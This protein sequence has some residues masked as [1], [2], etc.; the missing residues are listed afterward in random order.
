MIILSQISCL[1]FMSNYLTIKKN[2]HYLSSMTNLKSLF[3]TLLLLIATL[4]QMSITAQAQIDSVG[5]LPK[6]AATIVQIRPDIFGI[7]PN[8]NT[9]QRFIAKNL[10]ARLQA[11]DTQVLVSGIIGRIPPN[12]RMMGTPFQIK[13]I[14]LNTSGDRGAGSVATGGIK[15]PKGRGTTSTGGVKPPKIMNVDGSKKAIKGKREKEL[16]RPQTHGVVTPAPTNN[17]G[18]NN[19]KMLNNFNFD[20]SNT[21]KHIQGVVQKRGDNLF[22]IKTADTQYAP[23]NLPVLYQVDGMNVTLTGQTAPPPPNVRMAGTPL[24]VVTIGTN[25]LANVKGVVKKLSERLYVIEVGNKRYIPKSM[26]AAFKNDGRKVIIS[27]L[28][29]AIPPTAKMAGAPIILSAIKK[30][31]STSPKAKAKQKKNA[32]WW[33]FWK[34]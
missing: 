25:K 27:G 9:G 18:T 14:E 15:P 2:I 20:W 10:P 12:V 31:A 24:K 34:Q 23:Q 7:V 17:K 22:I 3:T 19:N 33:R 4:L 6:T 13:T 8:D 21:I 16:A 29:E 30:Q 11:A 32:P 26:D 5:F 1:Q 28:V